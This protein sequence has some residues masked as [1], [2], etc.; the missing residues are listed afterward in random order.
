L[1]PDEDNTVDP[2][3]LAI[4]FIPLA[5]YLVV[6]GLINLSP[7]P[8]LTTGSRDTLALALGLSG[9]MIAGPMEL[10][11]PER[12]AQTFGPYVWG[13]MI[14][15]Y[16]L[17]CVLIALMGK[18]RLVIYNVSMTELKPLLEQTLKSLDPAATSIDE[19]YAMPQAFVQFHAQPFP[20][21]RNVT[22]SA[23]G[24]RQSWQSWRRLE[25]A[26]GEALKAERGISNPY[27]L[28][29]LAGGIALLG[30]STYWLVDQRQTV[31]HA[32]LEML[33]M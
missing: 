13:L 4:A 14:T 29:L 26:L 21:L 1:L 30:I 8:F 33:R 3:H 15:L 22:L 5:M 32:L 2:L 19:T 6:L 31:A 25:V 24:T 20:A 27:G 9:M 23:I 17:T 7:R 10:F 11:L 16:F 12:A 28:M 18:P